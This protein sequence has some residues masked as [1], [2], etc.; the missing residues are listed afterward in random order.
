MQATWLRHA[1]MAGLVVIV[2]LMGIGF[3]TGRG[4][5]GYERDAYERGARLASV[6]FE[7]R[8]IFPSPQYLERAFTWGDPKN[9]AE[10]DK[11]DEPKKPVR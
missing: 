10:V 4:L 1:V 5:I 7:C 11:V 9:C 8:G 6:Y 2:V 3:L